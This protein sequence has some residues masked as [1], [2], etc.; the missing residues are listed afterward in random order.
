MNGKLI[1][2]LLLALALYAGGC[3]DRALG[4]DGRQAQAAPTINS[5]ACYADAQA[6]LS[7]QWAGA[8]KL[9]RAIIALNVIR[10][11]EGTQP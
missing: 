11:C 10:V 1:T 7:P 9:D 6:K 8:N 3:F 2:I 5:S 4:S